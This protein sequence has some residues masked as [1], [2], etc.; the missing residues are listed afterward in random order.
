MARILGIDLGT[1]NSVMAF[2]DGR[3]PKIIANDEGARLTPSVVAFSPKGETLVGQVARRQA[4]TNAENTIYS[5]KRFIGRRWTEVTSEANRFP[6][7]VQQSP[8]GDAVVS[9]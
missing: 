7:Q 6:Y 9:V 1:T 8:K 3:E 2:W 5:I 4:V